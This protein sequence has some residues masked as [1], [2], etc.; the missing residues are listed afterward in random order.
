MSNFTAAAKLTQKAVYCI[1]NVSNNCSVQELS[2]FV[3]ALSVKVISCFEAKP[4]RRRDVD[5]DDDDDDDDQVV[6]RPKRKA[7][8]LCIDKDDTAKL[9][10]PTAWPHSVIIS[11]WFF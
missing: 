4:R 11:E 9:L 8:R 5:D 6:I 2:D 7:F 3:S 1:D 10:N